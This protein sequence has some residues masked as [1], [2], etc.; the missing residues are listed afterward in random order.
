VCD[1]IGQTLPSKELIENLPLMK[2]KWENGKEEFIKLIISPYG[3]KKDNPNK[4]FNLIAIGV[5]TILDNNSPYS[6]FFW[7]ELDEK[8]Y[9]FCNL[10]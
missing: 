6:Y 7:N 4:K 2:K 9:Q 10:S 8:L 1:W 3:K 5:R